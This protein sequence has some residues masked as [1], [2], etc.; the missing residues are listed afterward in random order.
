MAAGSGGRCGAQRGRCF[1]PS[2]FLTSAARPRRR[3]GNQ[4]LAGAPFLSWPSAGHMH[5][6]NSSYFPLWQSWHLP[7]EYVAITRCISCLSP[8]PLPSCLLHCPLVPYRSPRHHGNAA[9]TRFQN[10]AGPSAAREAHAG[11]ENEGGMPAGERDA[12]S[13]D[14]RA[15]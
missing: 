2:C 9:A 8:F 11:V 6:S 5:I 12:A 4:H 15:A 3:D 14:R 1:P 13:V 10:L 7:G